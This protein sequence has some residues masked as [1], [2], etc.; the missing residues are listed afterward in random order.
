MKNL[1]GYLDFCFLAIEKTW[2]RWKQKLG[3]MLESD[4]DVKPEAKEWKAKSYYLPSVHL[5][6]GSANLG[7]TGKQQTLQKIKKKESYRE[8]SDYIYFPKKLHQTY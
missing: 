7:N 1:A 6:F 5:C 4:S 3:N 8:S 2:K